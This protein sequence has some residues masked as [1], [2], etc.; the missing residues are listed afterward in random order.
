MAEVVV[1][2]I[3]AR[4]GSERLP[5]KPLLPLAG[6]PLIAHTIAAAQACQG[7][8]HVMVATDHDGIFAA[9]N[10][11]G[12]EADMTPS[13]LPS[14]S[15]RIGAALESRPGDLIINL[16]GDEPET[17]PDHLQRCLDALHE[18]AQAA[19]STLST[20]LCEG[21]LLD[22]DCVKVVCDQDDRALYFSRGPIGAER[23]DLRQAL[24]G[25]TGRPKSAAARHL[26][27]YAYRRAALEDFLR[28]EPTPLESLERLEQL[29]LLEHG[30]IIA[31]R[32]VER[33]AR[34]VDTETDLARVR[35]RL[36]GTTK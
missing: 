1:A 8:D 28:R 17:N 25:G 35:A 27:I 36:M 6:K 15:D 33:A 11:W 3:P 21:E 12:A 18:D 30:M 19:V 13:E 9:A 10:A 7:I 4:Y 16:Q 29:R 22:P 31:V 23:E 24:A 32:S 5:G 20:P 26:G 14:G 2:V 34:G